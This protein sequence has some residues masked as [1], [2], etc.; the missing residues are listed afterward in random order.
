MSNARKD[1]FPEGASAAAIEST[2]AVA[3]DI[4]ADP[5]WTA[6]VVI[7][8]ILAEQE[9]SPSL[10]RFGGGG[11]AAAAF[12]LLWHANNGGTSRAIV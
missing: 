7:A 3:Q 2:L 1:A 12:D 5:E 6:R 11:G 9:I 8:A 10:L 4:L